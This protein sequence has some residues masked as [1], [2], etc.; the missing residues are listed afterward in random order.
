MSNRCRKNKIACVIQHDTCLKSYFW[1]LVLILAPIHIMVSSV[2]IFWLF[3]VNYF[4]YL[5]LAEYFSKILR[6][7][8]T[9]HF[10]FLLLFLLIRGLSKVNDI[11]YRTFGVY[12]YVSL[13]LQ[14]KLIVRDYWQIFLSWGRNKYWKKVTWCSLVEKLRNLLCF[15]I[16]MN[17][18]WI[19]QWF[20][21]FGKLIS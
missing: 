14:K 19:F 12:R 5:K 20:R 18:N 11:K 7:V 13:R 3:L 8:F 10:R 2:F 1:I 9:E 4:T 17:F 16:P 21:L 6:D 15:A